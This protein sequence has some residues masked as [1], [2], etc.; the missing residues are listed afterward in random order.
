MTPVAGRITNG[1]EYKLVFPASLLP[2][3]LSPGIPIDRI[4]SMLLQVQ[5]CFF[6]EM[7]GRFHHV[8]LLCV[9]AC[10]INQYQ[11][12]DESYHGNDDFNRPGSRK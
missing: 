1:D 3:F 12:T 2:C 7:I 9:I 4:V 6:I 8:M 11:Q 5:A 10:K